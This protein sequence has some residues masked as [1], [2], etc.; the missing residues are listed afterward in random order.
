MASGGESSPLVEHHERRTGNVT[1]ADESIDLGKKS[2]LNQSISDSFNL[3]FP[4]FLRSFS[5]GSDQDSDFDELDGLPDVEFP[6]SGP[7]FDVD[8]EDGAGMQ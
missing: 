4:E 5:I 2:P 6:E 7:C 3:H 8:Q 1:F